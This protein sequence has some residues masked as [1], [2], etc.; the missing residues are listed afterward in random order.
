[1]NL[2][3]RLRRSYYEERAEARALGLQEGRKEA[4]E[5]GFEEGELIGQRQLLAKLLRLKFGPLPK[6]A[7]AR[8]SAA[9]A[10]ELGR[11]TERVL[12]ARSLGE[13]WG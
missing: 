2:T 13:I 3:E 4:F 11:W 12:E 9:T 6:D 5:E 8:L 1:M 10:E 7:S